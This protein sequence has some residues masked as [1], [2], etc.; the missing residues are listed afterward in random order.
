MNV[1][2][3]EFRYLMEQWAADSKVQDLQMPGSQARIVMYSSCSAGDR[4]RG[5]V[6]A[7]QC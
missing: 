7:R 5:F 4:C 1:E 3:F 6:H 2:S